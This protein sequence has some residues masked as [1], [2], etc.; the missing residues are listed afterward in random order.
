MV[1]AGARKQPTTA[2]SDATSVNSK[3]E[4]TAAEKAVKIDTDAKAEKP[5]RRRKADK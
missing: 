5:K 2:I 1:F 4:E 3:A